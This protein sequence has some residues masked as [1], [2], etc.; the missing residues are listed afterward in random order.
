MGESKFIPVEF[1]T[2]F[3][4]YPIAALSF[5]WLHAIGLAKIFDWRGPK[6]HAMTY[7]KLRK[8]NFLWGKGIVE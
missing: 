1:Q 7:Q 4:R 2:I 6:P 5:A 8:M 3:S